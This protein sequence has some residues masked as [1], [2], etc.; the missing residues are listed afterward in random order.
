MLINFLINGVVAG[1]I[2][3][4]VIY[5]FLEYKERKR[6]ELVKKKLVTRLDISMNRILTSIR[7][8]I[9]INIHGEINSSNYLPLIKSEILDKFGFH[10]HKFKYLELNLQKQLLSEF[11]EAINQLKQLSTLF[12]NF[13]AAD[14]WYI[15]KIFEFQDKI[16]EASFN[17]VVFPEIGMSQYNDDARL[18]GPRTSASQNIFELCKFIA[19]MKN[20]PLITNFTKDN[21]GTY[22][23]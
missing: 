11:N 9:D 8:S 19:E 17:Y 14:P 7:V 23:N 18:V 10:E 12:I 13:R 15:E 6:W 2:A 1:I 20:S 5:I 3:S 16:F 22:T 4:I 21:L